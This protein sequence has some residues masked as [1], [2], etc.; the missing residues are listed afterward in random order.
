M[1]FK[2]PRGRC[3]KSFKV[4]DATES[5]RCHNT[6]HAVK[7]GTLGGSYSDVGSEQMDKKQVY[8][9]YNIQTHKYAKKVNY[10]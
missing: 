7:F 5:C 10:Q 2:L 8:V 3:H 1:F 6:I 4:P 9:K